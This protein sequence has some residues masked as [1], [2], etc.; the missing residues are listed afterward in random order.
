MTLTTTDKRENLLDRVDDYG[1]KLRQ[2]VAV[3]D[4]ATHKIVIEMKG[5]EISIDAVF[6]DIISTAKKVR[7][8][9]GEK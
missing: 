7:Q 1:V 2:L 9:G 5:T 3:K 6:K 4:G 8:N